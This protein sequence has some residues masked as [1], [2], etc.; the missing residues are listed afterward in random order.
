MKGS[1][2]KKILLLLLFSLFLFAKDVSYGPFIDKQIELTFELNKED[3][4]EERV[5]QIIEQKEQLFND[6]IEEI[7]ADKGRYL[8]LDPPFTNEIYRLQKIIAI[9][10]SRG[11]TYAVIR[12]EV[13]IKSYKILQSQHEMSKE[14]L[15]ALDLKSFDEFSKALNDIFIQ[16][17][18]EINEIN[19][20]D[21]HPL[22]AT[23][24]DSRVISAMKDR[25]KEYYAI[26]D[27]NAELLRDIIN[28]QRK[29]Y[30]L[31]KYYKYGLIRVALFIN[32]TAFAQSLEPFLKEFNL[33]TVKVLLIIVIMIFSYLLRKFFNRFM[34]LM[35]LRFHLRSTTIKKI[36]QAL[37][38]LLNILA[39]VIMINLI[40]YI[41]NDFARTYFLSTIFDIFYIVI[42]MWSIYKTLNIIASAKI[43]TIAK[44]STNL[45][46]ELINI[47][48]KIINFL[49][50]LIT[51]LI[52][53]HLLGVNLTA[54]L[55]GLGIGGFAIALAAKDSLANFFGTLSIL[56]SNTFS[57]GDWIV[58]D[59]IEGVV[60][61]IGLR[62]TTIRTF[63]NALISIPNL[64]LANEAIKNWNRR[65]VGR[66]IKFSIKVRFSN[67]IQKL[68]NAIEEIK[69]Y[70]KENENIAKESNALKY[71]DSYS[72]A[73]I[74]SKNDAL[75][76]KN[77]QIAMI[78]AIEDN[79]YR[80]M[81]YCFSVTTSWEEWAKVQDE[82]IF[83]TIKI[84]QRNG[85][86]IALPS[87]II[88]HQDRS[89]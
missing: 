79:G 1:S 55:S 22:L 78:D 86:E 48:I 12:D 81:V 28:H 60:V 85:I 59:E 39:F 6:R 10:K 27:I 80:L 42:I 76:I 5:E 88:D 58:I 44:R 15:Y 20:Q 64:K 36:F 41:Y 56:M 16:N 19:S 75:G 8:K 38:P 45:K 7:L 57:Q 21:Y 49:L 17:Q 11:N 84:L 70:L 24:G 40:V 47:T 31:N 30:R 2:L 65:K 54:I 53:L 83:E 61:E 13:L 4:K 82:V 77:T 35:F 26:L 74:V 3:I 67:D 43:N 25:I 63:D 73:K 68:Q 37:N 89:F 18:K 50:F 72:T 66:R 14:I 34:R 9:N 33:S 46:S 87:L 32:N 29:M 62:V 52:I 71:K 51:V 69:E 23:Q